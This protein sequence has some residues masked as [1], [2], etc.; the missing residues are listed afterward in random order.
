[1]HHTG[2]TE[3]GFEA[4][5]GLWGESDFRNEDEYLTAATEHVGHTAEIYLGLAA[6]GDAVQEPGLES[7]AVRDGIH[8]RRLFGVED[9][10]F[11]FRHG[12]PGC[13]GS[14]AV[15]FPDDAFGGQSLD[16]R[17]IQ[18]GSANGIDAGATAGRRKQIEQFALAR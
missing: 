10:R 16:V 9:R 11:H 14:N 13:S 3:A 2:C 6:A 8:S 7:P 17:A 12:S 5:E 15:S 1:M 4:G 18:T